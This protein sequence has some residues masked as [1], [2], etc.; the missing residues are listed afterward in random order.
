MVSEFLRRR[1]LQRY[2]QIADA[3][4]PKH[5]GPRRESPLRV[6]K[7]PYCV[8]NYFWNDHQNACRRHEARDAKAVI[9]PFTGHGRCL[10][11][12]RSERSVF[13][14]DASITAQHGDIVLIQFEYPEQSERFEFGFM[15]KML[16]D[17]ADEYFL[18]FNEGMF[19]LA[20]IKILGVEVQ[21]PN[22]SS[23]AVQSACARQGGGA[24]K[25]RLSVAGGEV[26][27]CALS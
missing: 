9:G 5:I 19:P 11:P 24:D 17:F 18:A 10:E 12:L 4:P 1:A 16:V 3:V 15:A 14:F 26:T 25:L 6:G 23:R 7:A 27:A 8:A 2:P 22:R 20:D 21:D 13:W